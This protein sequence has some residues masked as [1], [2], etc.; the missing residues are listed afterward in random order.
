MSLPGVN[1]IIRD[2][3]YTLSRT[4]IPVGPRVVAIGRRT[5]A[6][7]TA[8][9]SDLDPYTASNESNVIDAF[10]AESDLHRAYLE[11]VSGGATRATLIALPSDTEFDHA[12][13]TISSDDYDAA[14]PG[15]NL[16][17]DAFSAAE[18]VRA[19]IIV[20]WGRGGHPNDFENPATPGNDEE[21]GFHADNATTANSWLVKVAEKCAEI[22][23]NS[24]P[25]FAVLGVK[26]YVGDSGADG[27]MTPAQVA[28]HVTYSDLISRDSSALGAN[29]IYVSVVAGEITPLGYN[30]NYDFGF[31]N[32][33]AMYAGYVSQL[34]SWSAATGKPIYNVERIRYNPT[35]TQLNN[36]VA[37]GVVPIGLNFD[38][39]A[40]W[41]DAQT[42]GKITSDYVRLTTLRIV[43]DSV[44]MVRQVAQQF[45]G[46]AT[47]IQSRNALETAITAGLRGMQQLGAL[48]ASDFSVTYIPTENK[49]IVDLVLNPAFE[50]RN[51]EVRVSVQL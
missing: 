24:H 35:R 37:K 46:E 22:T 41:I 27:G 33:A 7:K 48:L 34:D 20:P 26:P 10:G 18:A 42:F 50:L 1:T 32:S 40:T 30:R 23:N 16:F 5:T 36:S 44:Q 47:N 17:D 9:V 2:R 51:L 3:F 45:I 29:G 12:S 11:L 38:R 49:A 19:D 4:E 13:G 14:N 39:R 8:G 25:C 15:G 21:L 28:G 31:S 43:F 6:D